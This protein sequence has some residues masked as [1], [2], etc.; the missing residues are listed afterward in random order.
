MSVLKEKRIRKKLTRK[1]LAEVVGV[2]KESI[3]KYETGERTPT[4]DTKIKIA[5]AL[6]STVEQLFFNQKHYKMYLKQ[7]SK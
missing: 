1:A 2:S 6:D 4:D 5:K 3:Y 7:K